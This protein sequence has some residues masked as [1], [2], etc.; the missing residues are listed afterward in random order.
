M[1]PRQCSQQYIYSPTKYQSNDEFFFECDIDYQCEQDTSARFV[2]RFWTVDGSNRT[3]VA[4]FSDIG[5]NAEF[6][7]P[8]AILNHTYLAGHLGKSVRHTIKFH[9]HLQLTIF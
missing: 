2:V 8:S 4:E 5:C 7:Y 6:G 9:F 1:F 3:T